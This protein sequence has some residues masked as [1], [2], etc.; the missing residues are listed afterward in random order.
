M[1][2]FAQY[3]VESDKQYD[4]RIKIVGDI[5]ND[6]IKALKDKLQKF[7][8]VSMSDVKKTPVQSKPTDFPSHSNERVNIMDVSFRYPATM[9]QIVQMAELLGVD[10]DR[11]SMNTSKYDDS[12]DQELMGIADQNKDLLNSDYPEPNKEQKDLQKDYAAPAADKEVVK[13]SAADSRF[14]VAGGNTPAAETTNELPMG[15]NSPMTDIKRPSKP[16][17]GNHPKG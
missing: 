9:P 16:A 13:N 1:K 5:D 3:L 4:Y 15:T 12:I 17:T 14:T 8:P 6:V 11:V 10:A 7:E 2:N